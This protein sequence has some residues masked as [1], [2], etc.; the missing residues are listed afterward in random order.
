MKQYYDFKM[1]YLLTVEL[2]H[3]AELKQEFDNF[4]EFNRT[5]HGIDYMLETHGLDTVLELPGNV[6]TKI[7][8]IRGLRREY[9][10]YPLEA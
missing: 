5:G 9:V 3:G 1:H 2:T 4:G 7:R 8:N 6:K 10:E